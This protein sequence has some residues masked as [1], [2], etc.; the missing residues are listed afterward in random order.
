MDHT[1]AST[2]ASKVPI[3]VTEFER[4]LSI[5][6]TKNRSITRIAVM[7]TEATMIGLFEVISE[8]CAML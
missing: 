5:G 8:R 7:R 3:R 1:T 6:Q 2:P 4:W